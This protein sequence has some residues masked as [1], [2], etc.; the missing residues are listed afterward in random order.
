M[1]PFAMHPPIHNW[2]KQRDIDF[3]KVFPPIKTSQFFTRSPWHFRPAEA[4]I[5]PLIHKHSIWST[6]QSL[7]RKFFVSCFLNHS[8]QRV[9]PDKLIFLPDNRSLAKPANKTGS[10]GYISSPPVSFS[11]C[12]RR[13]SSEVM[14]VVT[15]KKILMSLL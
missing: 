5:Q 14:S 11:S 10:L 12:T 8:R 1:F 13:S 15:C 7:Q 3:E 4:P 9:P 2:N 6:V